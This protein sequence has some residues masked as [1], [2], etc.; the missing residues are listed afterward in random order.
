MK[1][2]IGTYGLEVILFFLFSSLI[3]IGIRLKITF[4]KHL[5]FYGAAIF[6]AFFLYEFMITLGD[7]PST[8]I[9]YSDPYVHYNPVLGYSVHDSL[10]S[11]DA[12]KRWKASG[13]EIYDVNYSFANGRRVTPNSNPLSNRYGL[14]LGGSC[15]FGEGVNDDETLPYYYNENAT[16]KINIRN[17][18]FHGY[19]THQV[20]TIVKNQIMN[21]N[22]LLEAKSVE[23]FYWFINAHIPRA[24]GYSPWDKDGPN[25]VIEHGELKHTGSFR[26]AKSSL[27]LGKLMDLIWDNSAIYNRLLNARLSSGEKEVD[28]FLALVDETNRILK[29]RGFNFTVLIQDRSEIDKPFGKHHQAVIKKVKLFFESHDIQFMDVNEV[30]MQEEKDI[31]AMQI[32]GDGHP[33]S[34]FH[35]I[36]ATYLW[37]KK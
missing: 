28:L 31:N 22:A 30:L 34:E 11:I 24:N 17:Y 19:G 21:D 8:E 18:G 5:C 37:N 16:E 27:F 35:Q 6:F 10:F 13:K 14:F 9:T 25:Y 2:F 29:D 26:S 1:S 33:T 36:V 23:V 32:A 3:W 20:H 4:L 15:T 12:S 7:T